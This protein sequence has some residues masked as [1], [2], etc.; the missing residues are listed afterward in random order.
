M[1]QAVKQP[2][3]MGDNLQQNHRKNLLVD[4]GEV[5]ILCCRFVIVVI[6]DGGLDDLMISLH[7]LVVHPTMIV[8][9][10]TSVLLGTDLSHRALLQLWIHSQIHSHRH[11][12]KH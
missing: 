5:D 2:P 3:F 9:Q 8:R 6:Q 11:Q 12:Y 10:P 7:L 1:G 4:D